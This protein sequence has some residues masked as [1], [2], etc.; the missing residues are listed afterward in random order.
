MRYEIFV[1]VW[2]K[3]F[4][5]KFVEFALAS[6]LTPGN[7]PALS[8]VANVTYRIYTDRVSENYFKPEIKAL[9]S[10]VNVELIYFDD[11]PYRNTTLGEALKG[12]DKNVIKHKVQ[13]ETSRH[14][15]KL[16]SNIAKT[17]IMFLDSDFVFSDGSFSRIH[18]Q[19]MKGKKAFAGMFV[20]L[21]EEEAMPILSK[22]FPKPLSA[23]QLVQIGMTNMHPIPCSMFVDSDEPS[24]YPTQI[25][26]NVID[27][28]FIT[29]CFFPHPLMFEM[30]QGS[31]AGGKIS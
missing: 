7:L 4:V 26:W 30:H 9:E 27:K 5:R 15:M 21:A 23:R 1:T 31:F 22:H 13:R 17:A 24:I 16:A 28:G 6:Q 29:N 2:E 12:F 11:L 25:N 18:E 8:L 14:H 20:R 3:Y 10:L 19:R